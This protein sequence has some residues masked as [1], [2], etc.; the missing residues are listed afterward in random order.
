MHGVFWWFESRYI[1][2][3]VHEW[4]VQWALQFVEWDIKCGGEW[5]DT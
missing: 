2:K 3:C 4:Y 5:M 1:N